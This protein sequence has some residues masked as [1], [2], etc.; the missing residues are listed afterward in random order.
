MELV[1]HVTA[2]AT[3]AV[4]S[5]A[6]A[7][8]LVDADELDEPSFSTSGAM[9]RLHAWIA[10]RSRSTLAAARSCHAAP[11]SSPGSVDAPAA[12]SCSLLASCRR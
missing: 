12:P 2:T 10:S 7:V 4:S 9:R 11:S 3:V 8:H 5:A 1:L 6:A